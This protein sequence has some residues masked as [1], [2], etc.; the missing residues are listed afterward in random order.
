MVG[1]GVIVKTK[2]QLGESSALVLQPL[3]IMP[4]LVIKFGA[5]WGGFTAVDCG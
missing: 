1:P 4:R 3:V 2:N 5:L